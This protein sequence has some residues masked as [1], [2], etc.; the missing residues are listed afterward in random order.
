[1]GEG[2]VSWVGWQQHVQSIVQT[3][4]LGNQL[5]VGR[6]QIL[7]TISRIYLGVNGEEFPLQVVDYRM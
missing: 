2:M 7:I 6:L 3:E 1:M 4:F 5:N